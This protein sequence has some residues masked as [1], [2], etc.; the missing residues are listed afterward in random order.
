MA[1]PEKKETVFTPQRLELLAEYLAFVDRQ[2][3]FP[4]L[5]PTIRYLVLMVGGMNSTSVVSH[6]LKAL[7]KEGVL[8]HVQPYRRANYGKYLINSDWID[9]VRERVTTFT[10]SHIHPTG[11]MP[12]D[13]R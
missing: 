11:N 10:A 5:P 13:S 1:M 2:K 7:V 12:E 8:S 3:T 4:Q 9:E 6:H